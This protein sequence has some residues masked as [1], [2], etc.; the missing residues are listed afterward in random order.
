M[1][2]GT[3]SNSWPSW[4]T[5]I[6]TTAKTSPA[7]MPA[8]ATKTTMMAS[9][10]GSFL[11]SNQE[12]TGSRPSAMK[13]AAPMYVMIVASDA[14]DVRIRMP[15]PTPKVATSP[16]VNAFWI[17]TEPACPELS[18]IAIGVPRILSSGRRRRIPP[19]PHWA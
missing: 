5:M 16:R 4:S 1:S 8:T 19:R 18:D 13:I 12:M 10:R 7:T 15:T 17:F 9:Q 3:M 6:G 2:T 11:F 14:I